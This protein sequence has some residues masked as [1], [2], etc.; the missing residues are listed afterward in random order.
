MELDFTQCKL[1]PYPHQV[2]GIQQ[3][4]KNKRFG[5]FWEMRLG[6]SFAVAATASFLFQ[7]GLL[8][9]VLIACPAQVKDVW[10]NK[11]LGEITKHVF[12]PWKHISFD[13][14]TSDYADILAQAVE[15]RLLFIT[16]SHELLRQEDARGD[17][18]RVKEIIN[19]LEGKKTWLVFDEAAAFGSYKSLQTKSAMHLI[20]GLKPERLTLLDG[21]PIGNSPIEQYSK[22]KLLGEDV[23]GYSSF[24]HFRA[25]HQITETNVF[26]KRGKSFVGF[27]NQHLI[28]RRVR[29]FC[30]YLEQKDCLAMPEKVQ[31]FLTIPLKPKSW[32]RYCE[33][34]DEMVAEL[35]SGILTAQHASVKVLRLAQMC[36]GFVGGVENEVT[37]QQETVE[38][39]KE[40]LEGIMN[41]LEIRYSENVGF[42]CVVWC[43]WR[44]EIER[45]VNALETTSRLHTR[46]LCAY[47]AKKTYANQ[48]HPGDT[49][50]GPLVVVA[51]PQALRYGVNM[52][53]ATSEV[54]LS[55]DYNR[56][57]RSQAI[58]R[59]QAPNG[60][61]TTLVLDVL[62]TGP[63]GQKTVT[64]DIK[65]SLDG[66]EEV[67]RRTAG[68]WKRV[69]TEE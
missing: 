47:G 10:A 26:A 62:V 12:V 42:K 34:R 19:C 49:Y 57:T 27:K 58:E 13:S 32:A 53:K 45:L 63:N 38:L 64:W 14:S 30:E 35:D 48:L 39:S 1:T 24:F 28:D 65:Q 40:T 20:K 43:R 59:L 8:D 3:L 11:E 66:K 2:R 37:L 52:S 54:F 23:L 5:L 61:A 56:I 18:P 51:Q 7:A 22:F 60:R 17:F 36:S 50:D 44:P 33:F 69:L 6:K 4:F 25:V 46:V 31:T 68:E 9:A 67:A 55:Q 21:T 41:W 15:D 29:P 16:L